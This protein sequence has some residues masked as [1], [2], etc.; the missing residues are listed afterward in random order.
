MA[1]ELEGVRIS[2][3]FDGNPRDSSEHDACDPPLP[4][5]L[6]RFRQERLHRQVHSRWR[7]PLLLRWE[8]TGPYLALLAGTFLPAEYPRYSRR[9]GFVRRDCDRSWVL[10]L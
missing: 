5:L 9:H 2:W 6:R 8:S 7:R 4:A 3:E 10:R 1:T